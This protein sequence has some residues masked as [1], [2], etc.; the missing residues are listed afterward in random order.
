MFETMLSALL[1][2]FLF[3][4]FSPRVDRIVGWYNYR[5]GVTCTHEATPVKHT[6]RAAITKVCHTEYTHE[7]TNRYNARSREDRRGRRVSPPPGDSSSFGLRSRLNRIKCLR[8]VNC[9]MGTWPY[10]IRD[11]IPTNLGFESF[12]WIGGKVAFRF[13]LI[14]S[15]NCSNKYLK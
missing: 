15:L 4:F 2:F 14:N 11:W 9:I 8:H 6:Q 5:Y 3:F 12:G 7:Y 1:F 13:W 10:D